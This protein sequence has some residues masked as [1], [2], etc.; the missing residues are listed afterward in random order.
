MLKRL[1]KFGNANS[2]LAA[3]EFALIA[4]VMVLLFFGLVEVCNALNA[5]QKVT[6]VASTAADL[7]GQAKQM[8]QADLADVFSASSAIMSPFSNNDVSI[9]ITSI[10]G[11]GNKNE[12]RVVW[13]MTNGKG[14]AHKVN[15]VIK[16]GDPSTLGADDSGILPVTCNGPAQCSL[17]MAEVTYKYTSPYG[18]FI[19]GSMNMSDLFYSKPRRVISVACT[20]CP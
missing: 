4:P 1:N 18:K 6:S 5:H 12:G 11:D 2:G 7:V 8:S 20:D 14:I 15:D 16:V 13:S 19:I 10:A 17:V 3:V 9:V